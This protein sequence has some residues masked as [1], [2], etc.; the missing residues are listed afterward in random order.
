GP[1]GGKWKAAT[2]AAGNRL[3]PSPAGLDQVREE[4]ARPGHQEGDDRARHE[5][6]ERDRGNRTL[7]ECGPLQTDGPLSPGI[8]DRNDTA[9][10]PSGSIRAW[11]RRPIV[12][13]SM[14]TRRATSGSRQSSAGSTN[15]PT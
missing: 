7:D 15:V 10:W 12:S 9:R 5:V 13:E 11:R 4:V 2:K 3:I 1:P 6:R 8:P 14:F